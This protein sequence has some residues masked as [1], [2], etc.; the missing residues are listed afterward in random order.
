MQEPRKPSGTKKIEMER[1]I[2][3]QPFNKIKVN[4]WTKL[5]SFHVKKQDLKQNL[6]KLKLEGLDQ[7]LS[8]S[9]V[10]RLDQQVSTVFF[11]SQKLKV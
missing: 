10:G 8:N 4:I 3:T 9:K 1:D 11:P 7:T 2:G 5:N 6:S